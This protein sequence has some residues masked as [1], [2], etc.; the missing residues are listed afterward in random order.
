MSPTIIQYRSMFRKRTEKDE[1]NAINGTLIS[2]AF[3]YTYQ[4]AGIII[5]MN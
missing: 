2:G 5:I 3:L 4:M 1:T